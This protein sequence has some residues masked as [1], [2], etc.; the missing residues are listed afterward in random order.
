MNN[1]KDLLY[2]LK[3]G[4]KEYDKVDRRCD[5]LAG[6]EFFLAHGHQIAYDED[7]CEEFSNSFPNFFK[8]DEKYILEHFFE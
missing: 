7:R 3:E 4:L 8:Y 1:K 6:L 2:E 5:T